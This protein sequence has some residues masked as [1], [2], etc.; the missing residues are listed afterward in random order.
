MSV[1][2]KTY[3]KGDVSFEEIEAFISTIAKEAG[4]RPAFSDEISKCAWVEFMDG[5]GK[6]RSAFVFR[7]SFSPDESLDEEIREWV[8]NDGM[9]IV[10]LH[11]DDEGKRIT[12][13]V[14]E[15]F[16]GWHQPADSRDEYERILK[17]D[18]TKA[19][20]FAENAEMWK[21]AAVALADAVEVFAERTKNLDP[22]VLASVVKTGSEE[23]EKILEK[24]KLASKALDEEAERL[25][26]EE[27][28]DVAKE[29][30]A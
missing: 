18:S 17:K 28:E 30:I 12:R 22:S 29:S 21:K 23:P 6:R 25:A 1:D 24:L 8:G 19:E 9:T 2:A 11:S 7:S 14:A 27:T 20:R 13:A 15:R 5:N 4:V 10:S 26:D 16:G 3:L